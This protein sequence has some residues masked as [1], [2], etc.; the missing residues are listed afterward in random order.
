MKLSTPKNITVYIAVA[1]EVLGVLAVVLKHSTWGYLGAV[2]GFLVLL[3][4][5]F[6]PGL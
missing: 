2:L 1:L 3:A 4:G 5:N 6:F